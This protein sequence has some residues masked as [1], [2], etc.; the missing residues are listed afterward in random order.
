MSVICELLRKKREEQGLTI[1]NISEATS[2]RKYYLEAIEAGEFD[3]IPG[4]V[5]LKG[6]IRNYGE[7]LGL[8]GAALVE[9]YKKEISEANRILAETAA[10]ENAQTKQD[11][12]QN[13]FAKN[14]AVK[15][16]EVLVENFS[17]LNKNVILGAAAACLVVVVGGYFLFGDNPEPKRT[18]VKPEVTTEEKAVV[19][20][21]VPDP[22][23]A[24]K[25]D[26]N[27]AKN[28]DNQKNNNDTPRKENENVVAID[29]NSAQI[30]V[31]VTAKDK[32]WTEINVD[33]KEVFAGMLVKG[34]TIS[35]KG[36]K[37][38]ETTFGNI[39]VVDVTVNGEKIQPT[40]KEI[41]NSVVTRAYSK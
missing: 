2:I 3:K 9:T 1:A 19:N 25:L 14:T 37:S 8:D 23:L 7:Y 15:S 12:A 31:E 26:A 35:W 33:G 4:E 38:V 13:K 6:F 16:K 30:L 27:S 24:A 10:L 40:K 36:S 5:Y 28:V 39:N 32:C 29:K 17:S 21:N 34:Q 22:K 20:Q 11:Q 18:A 41:A